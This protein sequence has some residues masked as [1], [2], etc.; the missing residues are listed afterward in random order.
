MTQ[1]TQKRRKVRP[2]GEPPKRPS[3]GAQV[4]LAEYYEL[5][6]RWK[7]RGC[8]QSELVR[9]ELK[10]DELTPLRP[11]LVAAG[12]LIRAGSAH[13]AAVRRGDWEAAASGL[14]ELNLLAAELIRLAT[15]ERT[16][17]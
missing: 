7:A 6:A 12:Q 3:V 16:Q 4:T 17:R 11:L 2:D 15:E 13:A 5:R 8:S 9:A 14:D 1:D 10:L